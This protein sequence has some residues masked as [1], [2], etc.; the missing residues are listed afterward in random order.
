MLHLKDFYDEN[1][2]LL[3][4]VIVGDGR[5]QLET[6]W[7]NMTPKQVRDAARNLEDIAVEM[8]IEKASKDAALET[9]C[10]L[11]TV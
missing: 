1:G 8:M 7:S 11:E 10:A 9:A 2:L 3:W 6:D 5:I 4:T